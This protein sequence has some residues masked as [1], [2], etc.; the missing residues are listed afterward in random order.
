M[1]MEIRLISIYCC[2]TIAYVQNPQLF[3]VADPASQP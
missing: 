3:A 1:V 2:K